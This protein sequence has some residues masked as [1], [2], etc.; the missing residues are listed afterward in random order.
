[1]IAFIVIIGFLIFFLTGTSKEQSKTINDRLNGDKQLMADVI[2]CLGK[3]FRLEG[4]KLI[5]LELVLGNR[6]IM[7]LG[8]AITEEI[9]TGERKVEVLQINNSNYLIE[10]GK[11][12]K[13]EDADR[14]H[15]YCYM[16][17]PPKAWKIMNQ[18]N[19]YTY[20][21]L[22]MSYGKQNMVVQSPRGLDAYLE[23]LFSSTDYAEA[24]R[25]ED[26]SIFAV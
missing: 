4:K 5:N 24:K 13:R 14:V 21:L 20:T 12:E 15:N 23:E 1:M 11:V 10:E 16:P 18:A 6:K 22:K 25:R 26:L 8:T 17:L 3:Q 2:H 9:A 7:M 19:V